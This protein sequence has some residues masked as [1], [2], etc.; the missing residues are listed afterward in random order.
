MMRE[1]TSRPSS[2]V[3]SQCA[4]VGP[5][6]IVATSRSSGE[7][8]A[9]EDHADNDA[10]AYDE[11]PPPPIER[12]QC[13]DHTLL[14]LTARGSRRAAPMSTTRFTTSTKSVIVNAPASRTG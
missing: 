6:S 11:T 5:C 8:G 2:S 7:Q 13:S 14:S 4:A 9:Y 3:P 12:R 1:R 10:T